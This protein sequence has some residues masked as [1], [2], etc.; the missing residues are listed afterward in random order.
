MAGESAV[1]KWMREAEASGELKHIKGFGKPFKSD[2]AFA[3]TPEELKLAFKVLKDSGYVPP[4]V[5]MFK[6]LAELRTKLAEE[7]DEDKRKVIQKQMA[8]RQMKIQMFA[9]GKLT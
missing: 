9:E 5:E 7:T 8:E 2:D 3:A 1:D 4:Q 6:E